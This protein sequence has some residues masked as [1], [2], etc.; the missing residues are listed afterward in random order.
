MQEF[1]AEIDAQP[2]WER[3][4][5]R[6][7]HKPLA[8]LYALGQA[9]RG[10]RLTRY[11][12]AEP[13]LKEL[14]MEFGPPRDVQHPEQPVWRLRQFHGAPTLIWE[15]TNAERV[16]MDASG[17]PIIADLREYASFGL[18]EA[19]YARVR[20]EPALALAAAER[21]ADA[22]VPE[23]LQSLL[24][25]AVLLT[26][27]E[28]GIDVDPASMPPA[29]EPV[30]R[31]RDSSTRLR[32]NPIFARRVLIAYGHACA[33]C[34][35]APRHNG[36]LFGLEAAHI[37]WVNAGGSDTICNGIC[38]CRMHHVALDKGAITVDDSRQLQLSSGLAR[39]TET[40]E[41]YWRFKG[42]KLRLPPNVA[43]QP[44]DEA[45]AWHHK[46]VFRA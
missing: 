21:I 17:N 37:K 12:D 32:R 25:D 26:F 36:K 10:E 3:D 24:L 29:L 19:A 8:I 46:Q 42:T 6:A 14:L 2:A 16:R 45:L 23:S 27:A 20:A 40:D 5:I 31:P 34:S 43:H 15:V 9:M 39:S 22:L 38:L 28:G 7:P 35:I 18:S 33:I 44:T 1:T 11:V 30:P 41:L 13:R 4:G